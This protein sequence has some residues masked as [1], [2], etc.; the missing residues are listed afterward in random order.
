MRRFATLIETLDSTNKTNEKVAALTH[1]FN[2]APQEDALWAVALLSHRRPK[3]PVTTTLLRAWAAE[4]A[5]LP[6]WLF[7]ETY[8]IVGDLAETIALLVRQKTQKKPPTLAQCIA[9]IIA[10]KPKDEEEKKAYILMR[11]QGFNHFERFVFNKILTGGFRIGISQK[12]MT[13]A[14]SKAVKID[15][16]ILAHRL[17]GQWSP[18]QTTFQQ[19]IVAPN[20]EDQMAQPYPFFLA[21]A[22]EEG[23]QQK[24][25]TS[26][27]RVEHKWDGMRAQ[28]IVRGG[29][30]F[31]W[32]RGEELITD[33]FPELECLAE[34]LPNGTVVD[35]EL[36]PYKDGVIGNFNDLQK[37]IGRK[38]VTQK[39][40]QD[41]PIILMLY[42][43]LEW[44]G[45]D[46][47]AMPLIKRQVILNDLYQNYK[48]TNVPI[49][50]SEVLTFTTWEEVT[51]ERARAEEKRSEGLM[52]KHKEAPYAVGRKKG[53][54]WKWKSD[55][56][57]IDAVLTYAMR[58]H[59]RRTNLYSDYTFALWQKDQ[60]VTFA[61][62]YSG[63]TDAEI[64][65]VDR[66]VKKNTLDRFGPVRQVKPELV[67]EIAFE[68]LA[69]SPRH[70]SGVA[71]RFPRIL[72][73]RHDK[74]SAEANS[75][76]DL[77]QL[78]P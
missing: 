61:K 71:V 8:H 13:K 42:D 5:Q 15:E 62:A 35:G 48:G 52:L 17:M 20:P 60:L 56:K 36:I 18:E 75:L 24:E 69:P 3:R 27:W 39:I 63:L 9:E 44:E 43:L 45:K 74:K 64:K 6:K 26:D 14:L 49:L 46:I 50:L 4:A 59:G 37:R 12:L 2:T 34:L 70:K 10:L 22:L 16:N 29:K 30:H 38:T 7:E 55:P 77:K 31:L 23:F 51:Q 65:E 19:L 67:F 76:E 11:W 72:R 28:L 41:N 54:W 33:I 25:N 53:S 73:W 47:R 66:F 1:Y 21:Y 78:L 32:S 57:T 58:G 40:L 68:G